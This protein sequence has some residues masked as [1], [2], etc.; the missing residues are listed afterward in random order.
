[1]NSFIVAFA[2]IALLA[3]TLVHGKHVQEV[4]EYE[5]QQGRSPECVV[6]HHR[7]DLGEP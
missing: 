7:V 4:A 1:M 6:V 2:A 5:I 3:A